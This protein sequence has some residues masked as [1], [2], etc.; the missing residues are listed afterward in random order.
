LTRPIKRDLN[1]RNRGLINR[2]KHLK[3]GSFSSGLH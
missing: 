1:N 3:M 2:A